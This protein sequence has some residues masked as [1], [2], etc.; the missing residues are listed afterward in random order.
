M[1]ILLGVCYMAMPLAIVGNTFSDIWANRDQIL[2]AEKAKIKFAEGG[3]NKQ[4]LQELFAMTDADGSGTLSRKE[5]V[6]LIDAFGLG[7][8]RAQIKKLFKTIDDDNT[9]SVNFKEFGD[10]LFPDIEIEDEDDGAPTPASPFASPRSG[11]NDP[12][13]ATWAE[14]SEKYGSSSGGADHSSKPL[15]AANDIHG[16]S[17][18]ASSPHSGASPRDAVKKIPATSGSKK[19]LRQTVRELQGTVDALRED[20]QGQFEA[21]TRHLAKKEPQRSPETIDLNGASSAG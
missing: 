13:A 9:G 7:F 1:L 5:F 11:G 17:S 12:Q 18:P 21:I 3:F 20:M 6:Q 19:D 8:T 2:I 4:D 10:F 16:L 14:N 15:N